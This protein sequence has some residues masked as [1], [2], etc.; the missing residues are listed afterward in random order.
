MVEEVFENER[1]L[2]IRG[3]GVPP[4][5][6]VGKFRRVHAHAPCVLW[7]LESVSVDGGRGCE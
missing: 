6:T 2:P 5:S 3:W 1:L 7:L 4:L